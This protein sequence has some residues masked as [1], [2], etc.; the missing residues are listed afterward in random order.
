MIGSCTI[1]AAV[2]ALAVLTAAPAPG[3]S[4]V[5]LVAPLPRLPLP[6]PAPNLARAVANQSRVP[7]GVLRDRV[8]TLSLDIV[9]A[10]WRPESEHEPEVPILAFAEPGG[11][12]L[13]PGPL[14]RVPLGTEVRLSL[15][16]RSDS[17][18]VI[19]GLRAGPG[20]ADDTVHLAAGATREV[21]YRLGKPGTWF[22]WGAFKGTTAEDRNWLDSQLNGAI[23]VDALGASTRDHILLLS[24]WFYPYGDRR[25]K[26]EVVSVIN[27]KG[28]P[29]TERL[30]FP[31][32]DSVRFRVINTMSFAHP[33]HLHGFFYRIEELNGKAIPPSRRLLT[34]T[35]LVPAEGSEVFSFLP[36]TPG[37]WLF[38]CHFA[39]HVDDEASLVGSP[40][41]SAAAAALAHGAPPS[42]EH[43]MRGLVVALQVT[44]APGYVAPSM[45]N[46]RKIKLLV[47]SE[48]YRLPGAVPAIGF[49]E[50]KGDSVP[51]RDEVSLPA[52]VLELQRGRPVAITVKNNLDAP[53]AVHWHGLEIESYPDGV[54]HW[55]GMGSKVFTQIAPGDSFVAEFTPP[56]AG[57]FPYHSHLSD[58]LQIGS[59]MYGAIIVTDRPRDLAHD[60]LIVTGGGGPPVEA[61]SNSPFALVNGRRNPRPLRLTAGD[62]HRLRFV[63][64]H[65][66]WEVTYT[67]RND[68]TVARW[69]AVAKDGAD[70]PVALAT[71]RPAF[72]VMGPGET[73]DFEFQPPAP[74]E[75]RIDVSAVGGWHISLPVIVTP[76]PGARQ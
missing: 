48:P 41:D 76:R 35:D 33:M 65:P 57:T 75:W 63:T 23:V 11:A 70:V 32:G 59:G 69:R 53:T 73:A 74:G 60:H 16:N 43:S 58:R 10:G 7:A 14:V 1:A 56:R 6:K 25:Q 64:L 18:L 54:P 42:R 66:D 27:G 3:Q 34:N 13:V 49:I 2:T 26:F 47:Q 20:A 72:V 55:S 9:A 39:F 28:F 62:V 46:A 71:R 67:L 31:Q 5:P 29:H 44:P 51:P 21:R 68:S 45:A 19:G 61:P 36:T 4:V 30:T 8:L 50:Q 22:Y 37:N 40:P 24:E 12:P 38:H 15:R 52:P 17:A